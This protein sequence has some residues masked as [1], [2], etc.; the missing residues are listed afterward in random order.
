MFVREESTSRFVCGAFRKSA[1]VQRFLKKTVPQGK[2]ESSEK[3]TEAKILNPAGIGGVVPSGFWGSVQPKALS[4]PFPKFQRQ[5][6]AGAVN[7]SAIAVGNGDGE[8]DF[9]D[10]GQAMRR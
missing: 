2:G 1:Q 8:R 9:E 10:L 6:R 4:N 3:S 5:R 7:Q